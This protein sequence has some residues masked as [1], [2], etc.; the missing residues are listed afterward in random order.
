MM[1]QAALRGENT[2]TKHDWSLD[3]ITR[4][5][6]LPLNDLVYQAQE[7]HRQYFDP[8]TIQISTL[9]NIKTGG[10]P[11]DCAYCPQSARHKTDVEATPLMSLDAVLD[12]AREAKQQ[13]ARRFCMGAAWRSP[14]DSDLEQ[15][16]EMISVVKGLGMETCVTLGMLTDDQAQR[17]KTAGLDFY[18]HNIDCSESFY[19]TIITTR[20]YDDRLQTLASV[21]NAGINVCCGGIIGMGEEV[22]DRAGMLRT[23]A[24]MP[25]HPESVPINLLM[26][27][28]GTPLADIEKPDTFDIVRTIAVA[29][30]LMPASYVRLSAGRTEMSDELQAL[31]FMAGANSIFC[32]EKL[33]T[34][35]NPDLDHD[36]DL[37][38]RLGLKALH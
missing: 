13:G 26:Q 27:V 6:N 7:Q 15:V 8:N 38:R 14:N 35:D 32:G 29:R 25:S 9:L 33:L 21:R 3:E 34:A 16:L 20:T 5:F 2:Q 36:R 19:E 28:E 23:L 17:L 24:N 37:F 10:C 11:E 1:K 4:L 12:A 22:K 30:L 18:N 31:C